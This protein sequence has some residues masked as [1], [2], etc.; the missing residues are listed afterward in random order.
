MVPR[1]ER[2]R[3]SS[4]SSHEYRSTRRNYLR[5]AAQLGATGSLVATAGCLDALESS[6][7][8]HATTPI[9]EGT[10]GLAA[11]E[12][13]EYV[14]RMQER[15]GDSGPYG[16][17]GRK[18]GQT[19]DFRRA[20]TKQLHV[21]ENGQPYGGE[22][23]NLLVAADNALVLYEIPDKV[24]ENGNQHFLI[25]LWSAGRVPEWKR[26][27]NVLDGT[28]VFRRLQTGVELDVHTEDLLLYS[29][30][31]RHD[32]SSVPFSS[33]SPNTPEFESSYPLRG[34]S[35]EPVASET[36]VGEEGQYAIR[37][38]GEVSETQ[39]VIGV[40]EARWRPDETFSFVWDA[41]IEGGKSRLS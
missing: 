30:S 9:Q 23:D 40:C 11:E 25:L 27:G 38:S 6:S 22:K 21:T 12:F 7:V 2:S 31:S 26:G 4:Q 16:T 24:D 39:A 19:L 33:P 36:R 14:G 37:W 1:D 8:G 32:S 20:W 28:P 3:S 41:E 34:G 18:I 17:A 35:V 5:R 10:S 13:D 29:P 15:Y